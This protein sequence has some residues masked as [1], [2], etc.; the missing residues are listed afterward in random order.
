[1]RRSASR[2]FLVFALVAFSAAPVLAETIELVTYYPSSATTGDLHVTSLTVGTAYNGVTPPDGVAAIYDKL[3][4]GQGYTNPDPDPAALRVVGFPGVLDKVLFLPGAERGSLNVGI[5]TADPIYPLHV[6]AST[7]NP[8][9]FETAGTSNAIVNIKN[10]SVT[11]DGGQRGVNFLDSSDNAIASIQV[12]NTNPQVNGTGVMQLSTSALPRM[13]INATGNVGIGT[14]TPNSILHIATPQH[15]NVILDRTDS[16]DFLALVT[17]SIGSGLRFSNSNR[18]FIG[19]DSYADRND[20]GFGRAG[21]DLLTILPAGNVGIG[22]TLG[23]GSDGP[24]GPMGLLS[25]SKSG[26]A[27]GSTVARIEGRNT[28]HNNYTLLSAGHGAVESFQVL[29]N[30]NVNV[31]GNIKVANGGYSITGYDETNVTINGGAG[32]MTAGSVVIRGTGQGSSV[33][34]YAGAE[35][36]FLSYANGS[37]WLR[38]GLSQNSDLRLKTDVRPIPHAL[39]RVGRLRGVNFRWKNAAAGPGVQMGVIGQEVEKEFPELVTLNPE[40]EKSVSYT[41]MTA[42]LIEAIKELKSENDLLKKR[43]ETL[44]QASRQ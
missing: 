29:A 2:S 41:Q 34:F 21:P 7:T 40:G 33:E 11:A 13:T 42:A 16:S 38:G 36:N 5:G 28:P 6:Y 44:E 14:S 10:P 26:P 22:T 32:G 25:I 9:F 4:I 3:W 35:R 1:M 15:I 39:E 20:N 27:V 23:G 17:G 31:R 43:V 30:G 8:V 19:S 24:N 12:Y 18:F 37:A